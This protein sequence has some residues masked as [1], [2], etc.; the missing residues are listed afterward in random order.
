MEGH[1]ET[2]RDIVGRDGTSWGSLSNDG[3]SHQMNTRCSTVRLWVQDSFWNMRF[4]EFTGATASMVS[5]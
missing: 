4:D 2:S 1:N 5:I 3:T